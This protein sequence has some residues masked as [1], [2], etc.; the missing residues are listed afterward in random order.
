MDLNE[1]VFLKKDE[2]VRSLQENLRIPS[3]QGK[4][5]PGAPYGT[6]VCRSHV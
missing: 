4:P 3:I 5:A 2:I 1:A 6:E